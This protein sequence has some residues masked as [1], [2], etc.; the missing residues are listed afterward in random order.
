[1]LNML[2]FSRDF[3]ADPSHTCARQNST[4]STFYGVWGHWGAQ[5]QHFK[6]FGDSHVTEPLKMLNLSALMAWNP[7]KCWHWGAQIQHFKGLGA[8][9]A[10]KPLKMLNLSAL[11]GWNPLKC[12]ICWICW[13][14]PGTFWADPFHQ[15]SREKF[16]IFNIFNILRGLGPLRRSIQHFK[17]FGD[18]RVSK[19]LKMLNLSAPMA[20]NPL[21]IYL[22]ITCW[23]KESIHRPAPARNFSLLK[24]WGHWGKISV[25]DRFLYPPRVCKV[26]LWGQKSFPRDFLSVVVVYVFSSLT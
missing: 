8:S 6:G 14:S 9:K 4:Y 25:V 17:G 18:M 22:P 24:K 15:K 21:N 13:I 20:P 12:W 7:L 5:I 1:M 19:P 26:F 2:N 10:T 16:N 23:E 11:M 3:W